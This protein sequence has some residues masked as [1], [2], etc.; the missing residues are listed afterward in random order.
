MEQLIFRPTVRSGSGNNLS[1]HYKSITVQ[2]KQTLALHA[3]RI[4]R[5]II[6]A[7][8]SMGMAGFSFAA[9]SPKDRPNDQRMF[10]SMLV[11]AIVLPPPQMTNVTVTLTW[12]TNPNV[13]YQ[14][15]IGTN[16]MGTNFIG[17]TW[18]DITATAGY[19]QVIRVLDNNEF[20]YARIRLAGATNLFSEIVR[21]PDWG[22]NADRVNWFPPVAAL[23][24]KT[25][26]FRLWVCSYTTPPVTNI[27]RAGESQFYMCYNPGPTRVI[28]DIKLLREWN[29]GAKHYGL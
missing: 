4:V 11:K 24:C 22:F 3:Y 18:L 5:L 13:S 1:R 20:I 21:S 26:D 12:P 7:L 8:V 23:L 10:Q 17:T 16:M 27:I 2:E 15:V 6:P 28:L 25:P 19:S 14:V 29:E 9:Q